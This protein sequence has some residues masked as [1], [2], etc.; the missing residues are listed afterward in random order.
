[1]INRKATLLWHYFLDRYV[2]RWSS[3]HAFE[4]WQETKVIAH[5][6][7]VRESSAYYQELWTGCSLS[8][9][10]DFPII[11]KQLMMDHFDALNTLGI[12]KGEA[13][14]LALKAESTRDFT[15]QL[16]GNT[17][18][19][20]SGTSGNR[21]LFVVSPQE[22]YAWAGRV[23][24]KVLP[25]SLLA[26]HR[27]AFFLRA[28]SNLYGSV[29]GARLRFEFFDLLEPM[30]QHIHRLNV[31]Q[32]NLWIAPPSVLRLL[33]DA[34]RQGKLTVK[35]QRM[36]SV[37]EVLDP[38]DRQHIESVF[39]LRMH[40]VYQCTEGFLAAT[41]A[42]GTLHLN[43]DI[44]AFQKE[45]VGDSRFVPILTDFTRI[46]QPI[47]RYRLND[48]LIERSSPCP[49]GS[50]MTAIEAVE[51][52]CDDL[53]YLPHAVDQELVP[54]FPDLITRAIISAAPTATAYRIIQHATDRIELSLQSTNEATST[55]DLSFI[56]SPVQ[57][58][59]E[60][61]FLRMNCK[62]P[63]IIVTPYEPIAHGTRK[64]RRVERRFSVDTSH[65]II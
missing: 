18:G 25:G 12:H 8:D 13:F 14:A 29:S 44:V 21:G 23:L 42:H 51:G 22:Q 62:N 28:N 3:L 47:V 4:E 16:S 6:Q 34:Y 39:Q 11:D 26:S 15:P 55:K 1:M 35:P 58:A 20:S 48:L 7:L 24:S 33:A 49:C 56:Y 9:W 5:L 30:Q 61:L 31:Y 38:M 10:R 36:V 2:H 45:F 40:Q 41:C 53:F 32:P 52:R 57:T 60:S 19:M 43:E 46:A 27:I 17:I 50:L 65:S 64:L 59:L 37:A 54:I 63:R